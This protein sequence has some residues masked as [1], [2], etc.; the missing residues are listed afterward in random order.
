MRFLERAKKKKEEEARRVEMEKQLA[1]SKAE[2]QVVA[3]QPAPG[4]A[5]INSETAL[6]EE[7]SYGG[8]QPPV[9]LPP[10]NNPPQVDQEK[11]YSE[12]PEE[13]GQEGELTEELL[14]A[15]INHLYNEINKIKYHC[16]LM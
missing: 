6:G 11:T 10:S 12:E 1:Q 4:L 16:R 14:V 5:V 8:T 9:Q 13:G 7:V 15:H 2:Q 3:E